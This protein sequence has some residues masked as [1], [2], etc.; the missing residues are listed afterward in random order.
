[1]DVMTG[2]K[3]CLVWTQASVFACVTVQPQSMLP[4]A[5]LCA[6]L[7]MMHDVI[8]LASL[9]VAVAYA[10]MACLYR[11]Q[12]RY[13]GVTW[14]MMR[15]TYIKGKR[16]VASRQLPSTQGQKQQGVQEQQ[17]QEQEVQ[18]ARRLLNRHLWGMP[19]KSA[20]SFEAYRS[21]QAPACIMV[22]ETIH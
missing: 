5:G 21:V 19:S 16:L 9:P 13:L 22:H 2:T 17:G 1:M 10:G 18:Q 3:T 14:T 12:L 7:A 20:V 8:A 4:T 6:T 15:G 11:L